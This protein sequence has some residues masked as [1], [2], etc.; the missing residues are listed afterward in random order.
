MAAM[1]RL[2]APRN[3]FRSVE[4]RQH[5]TPSFT[6]VRAYSCCFLGQQRSW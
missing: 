6:N 4:P 1:P 5:G 3:V 2:E